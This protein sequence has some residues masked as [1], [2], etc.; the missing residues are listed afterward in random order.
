M[1]KRA[2]WMLVLVAAGCYEDRYECGRDQHCNLGEG[3][4]CE[5]TGYCTRYD[6]TCTSQ[7]RYAHAGE[8]GDAC[9][10]DNV[11]PVNPCAGG[12][13]PARDEGACFEAVCERMPACCEIAWLDTCAQLAQLTAD[14]NLACDTRIAITAARGGSTVEHW[15]ARYASGGW[16]RVDKHEGIDLLAW[17]APEPGSPDPRL[18]V[19]GAGELM[20]GGA[21]FPATGTYEQVAAIPI[22]HDGR[23]TVTATVK[24]PDGVGNRFEVIKVATGDGRLQAGIQGLALLT[25]GDINRDGYPDATVR[26]ASESYNLLTNIIDEMFIRRLVLTTQVMIETGATAPMPN[27]RAMEW[28]PLDDDTNLDLAVFGADVRLHTSDLAIG[29]AARVIDCIPPSTTRT[30]SMLDPPDN[31]TGASFTG[32]AVP[33][34]GAALPSVV[35]ASFP[36][37]DLYRVWPDGTVT[38]IDFPGEGCSCP[39]MNCTGTCPGPTCADC[40]YNNCGSC[41]AVLALVARDLDHD[42][43]LDLIAIDARLQLYI[44]KAENDAFTFDPVPRVTGTYGV[45]FSFFT[46]DV[47]VTGAATP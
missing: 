32:A 39:V 38:D 45:N 25:W 13:P 15:D 29:P 12:Q 7:R 46:V 9:F 47:S 26:G 27:I 19:A 30:C 5:V 2:L 8:F 40:T 3:G 4:R 37:R 43:D 10:E 24:V 41:P 17:V 34:M 33:A 42:H 28:L 14:C 11:V 44:G 23:D 35:I 31:L 21:S 18:V 1:V 22:D 36:R 6:I 20:I 16:A